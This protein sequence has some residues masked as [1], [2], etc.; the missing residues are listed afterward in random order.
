ML[1]VGMSES[2]PIPVEGTSD[3]R[4]DCEDNVVVTRL[5]RGMCQEIARDGK[6]IYVR[7]D[8]SNSV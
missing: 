1:G 5:S 6:G 7:I 2:A 4:R 3:C 8:D